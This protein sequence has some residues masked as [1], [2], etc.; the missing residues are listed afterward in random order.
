MRIHKAL[1]SL[2]ISMGQRRMSGLLV[3]AGLAFGCQ[4]EAG[5]P[6]GLGGG[7]NGSDLNDSTCGTSSLTLGEAIE[8]ELKNGQPPAARG[9]TL[10]PGVYVLAEW[11]LW[12]DPQPG[13]YPT[14]L[15]RAI[16]ELEDNG[17]LRHRSA[18][19]KGSFIGSGSYEA[20]DNL[21]TFAYECPGRR[22][23]T[24]L[25]YTATEDT[26]TMIVEEAQEV[27]YRRVQ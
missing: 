23:N 6:D 27:V 5:A 11:R 21:L 17:V 19:Q 15:R 2:T 12:L 10:V 8:M 18:N 1:S 26:I 14:Q 13:T 16:F 4:G 22:T 7:G 25:P 3:L 9:G 20:H 24:P